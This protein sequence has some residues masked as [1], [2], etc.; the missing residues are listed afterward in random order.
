MEHIIRSRVA[1]VVLLTAASLFALAAAFGVAAY[2]VLTPASSGTSRGFLHAADWLQF[3]AAVIAWAAICLV[4]WELVL[5]RSWAGAWETG[6]AAVATLL[7]AIGLL[8][9]AGS[10]ESSS[11]A[12]VLVA[13][14]VGVW[15]ALVLS[16]AAR[17]SLAEQES[18][19]A[20]AAP[21][22]QAV[23]WLV[24]AAGLFVLA[25]GLG[26]TV[27]VTSK[28]T[29]IA[30]GVLKAAGTAVLL[31]ALATARAKGYTHSFSALAATAGIA[32]L[33]AAF[34]AMATVA[35]LVFGSGVTL[36]GLR[37]GI[38]IALTIEVLAVATLAIAAWMRVRELVLT[39]PHLARPG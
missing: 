20:G 2:A 14:G 34:A 15:A 7:V 30:A 6:T 12:G 3:A 37:V 19:S 38:S 5:A 28:G 32:I 26:F 11:A 17:R 36:T 29:G 16:R 39:A 35:G 27:Q 10:G 22:R 24:A 8:V 33:A 23:L 18:A 13:V 25:V 31:G 1:M 21:Q 4:G 9:N